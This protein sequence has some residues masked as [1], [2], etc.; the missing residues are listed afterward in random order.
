MEP[1]R[2]NGGAHES[3]CR[4]T[5]RR[6][7][8]PHL[9]VASLGEDDLDPAGGNEAAKA[10]RRL[11]RPE[12]RLGD[13]TRLRRT[14]AG[15]V[16][17]HAAAQLLQ[18]VVGDFAVHLHPVGFG[19]LVSRITELMLQPPVIGEQEQPFAV[20]IEPAGCIHARCLDVVGKGRST[21]PVGELREDPIRFVEQ[22][23]HCSNDRRRCASG[24]V[25]GKRGYARTSVSSCA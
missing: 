18:C 12:R 8:A 16:E 22:D 6:R 1:I 4:M 23:E 25:R 2:P 15:A 21:F 14:G 3:Q 5:H 20:S 7:H 13:A 17:Q 19:Q 10:H 9:T 11:A 24:G